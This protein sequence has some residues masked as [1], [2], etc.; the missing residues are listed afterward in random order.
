M[1]VSNIEKKVIEFASMIYRVDE[2][3]IT[4]AT[5][6]A[7]DLSRQSIKLVAFLSLIE[8]EFD[9]MIELRTAMG[10]ATIGDFVDKIAEM[11][12]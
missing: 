6:I 7:E 2:D 5:N 3:S 12:A 8:D 10:I 1:D 9:V 4:C 11:V